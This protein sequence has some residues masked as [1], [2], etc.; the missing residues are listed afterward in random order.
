[1]AH[2]QKVIA[3]L[4]KFKSQLPTLVGNE[5]V[6]FALDNLDAQVDAYGLPLKRRKPGATR[7]AGR[8]ILKD[9]GDGDRSIHVSRKTPSLVE[10]TA[11]EYMIAHNAGAVI[12]S[13]AQV[14]KHTRNRK[15]R[16]ENV[17]AHTRRVNITLPARTF[18]APSGQLSTR[19]TGVLSK[20][21]RQLTS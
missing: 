1:M 13:T 21:L 3:G 19:L 17:M 11:N 5:V 7:D 2:W 9:T 6:Y 16:T 10:V 8:R 12:T 4:R 14:R 20:R 15:G 18:L